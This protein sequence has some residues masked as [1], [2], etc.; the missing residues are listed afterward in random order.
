MCGIA[1]F[2][3]EDDALLRDLAGALRH[4]GPDAEGFW[5]RP[6]CVS[7]AHTRLSIV[8]LHERSNQPLHY[9]H[10]GKAYVLVFNGEIYNYRELRH[11]LEAS[12]CRFHTETDSEVITAGYALWGPDCVRRFNGMW[13]FAI[14]DESENRLF[15]SRDRF[16]KKPLYYHAAESR[17]MFASEIKAI[18]KS[19]LVSRV[20]DVERISDFIHFGLA[21]HTHGTFFRDVR[22]LPAGCNGALDLRTGRWQIDR[23]YTIP[24]GVTMPSVADIRSGL[25]AAVEKRLI[26]DVPICLSLSGGVDSSSIAAMVADVHDDRMVA[27]T[28]TSTERLGDETANVMKLLAVYPQF[29]LVKVPIGSDNL[30]SILERIV[31]HMDEPFIFDAPF[32]RWKIAEAIHQHGFKVSITGEGADEL[33]GGYAVASPFFLTDLWRNH[34][35]ARLG[36]ELACTLRQPDWRPTLSQ[37]VARLLHSREQ[38]I[39]DHRLKGDPRLRCRLPPR[40]SGAAVHERDITLKEKLYSEVRTFFLPYLLACNDKMYMAHDVEARA[41]FL[42]VD[43]AELLLQ[44][45]TKRLI[46]AG[47]RKYPLRQSMRGLVPK[48]VLFDRRKIGFESPLMM[49]L[50]QPAARAWVHGLFAEPRTAAFFDP[51]A[52]LSAYDAIPPGAA[53]E[54]FLIHAITL[55]LWMR[56]FDV[57]TA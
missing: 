5:S 47:I 7:L 44:I 36:F 33:L 19:P 30:Q 23:Y 21:G 35:F 57:T 15:L 51:K 39:R 48:S 26:S 9:S 2:N 3:W 11:Q 25:R 42:D 12:G 10:D 41:P 24:N 56:Q 43:L 49:Q 32:V 16:G 40:E 55:E 46:V 37:F 50:T 13:A 29:E 22:Q 28:T 18:I 1:G 4:R 34:D 8:D 53:V 6:G 31:Y 27:F 17:F 20:A 45:A 14:F 38:R 54:N 52:F